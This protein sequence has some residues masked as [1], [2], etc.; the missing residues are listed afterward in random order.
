MATSSRT[1][2]S[3]NP[4]GRAFRAARALAR[5]LRE[6]LRRAS[7]TRRHA[8]PW[9]EEIEVEAPRALAADADNARA[10]RDLGDALSGLGRSAEAQDAY[11]RA[12]TMDALWAGLPVVTCVGTTFAGRVGAGL[13]EAVGMPELVTES[14]DEYEALALALARDAGRL[15][16]VR[17]KLAQQRQVS[18]L[19]D[20]ARFT[21]DLEAAYVAMHENRLGEGETGP[22]TDLGIAP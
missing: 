5:R 2:R 3:I 15:G 22:G 7:D 17:T 21:R 6:R 18:P 16:A 4:V 19:F 9:Y 13:L 11:A 1:R 8:R 12:V 20:N 10:W 14:L